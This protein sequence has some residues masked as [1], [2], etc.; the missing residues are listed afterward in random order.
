MKT[1]MRTLQGEAL[2][3]PPIW[4]MRQAGRYL[5]EY[6][7]LRATEKDFLSFCY[8]PELTVEATLQPIRRFG[9]DA[10]IL[11][12]DILV[13]P[14]GLG[15]KVWFETGEGPR[16]EVK[17]LPE[18]LAQLSLDRQTEF[19]APVYETVR[20]LRRELPTETTLIGFSAS[21][22]TLA[23]YMLQGKGTRDFA[24]AREAAYRHPEHFTQLIALLEQAVIRHASA[25]I[26][27]GAE[28]IQLFD[29]WAGACPEMLLMET[30][31]RPTARI[32]KALK[33]KYPHVPVIGFP[34]GIGSHL[35]AYGALTGVDALGVDFHSSLRAARE[36]VPPRMA[37]QGNLDPEF[38]AHASPEALKYAVA[39]LLETMEGRPYIF[40]LGHGILPHTPISQ[41]EILL[42]A[43]R[44]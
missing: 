42:E 5:P 7:A 33:E 10:S 35:V 44:T 37:L 1:L 8:N 27:A 31:S 22:W 38:L 11:F 24:A 4:L 15:Q 29:S 20:I 3:R 25:Q 36:V 23:C 13:V 34:K 40:N 28:V 32:V 21:P 14:H 30:V 39:Q 18:L 19:L 9:F 43:V 41:V 16:L 6:R 26:D 12:S 2:A 17:P